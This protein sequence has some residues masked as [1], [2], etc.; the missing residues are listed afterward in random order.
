MLTTLRLILEVMGIAA[1][2]LSVLWIRDDSSWEPKITLLV[3][4]I[5]YGQSLLGRAGPPSKREIKEGFQGAMDT[6]RSQWAAE[7]RLQPADLRTAR[8]IAKNIQWSLSD[9][10][11]KLASRF[12]DAETS[13]LEDILHDLRSLEEHQLSL[14]G[15]ASYR[16]FWKTGDDAFAKVEALLAKL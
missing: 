13:T 15:G 7:K 2:V 5:A 14:D 10:R 12:P 16:A 1:I 3:G 11:A 6:Y 9:F 4:L 8:N